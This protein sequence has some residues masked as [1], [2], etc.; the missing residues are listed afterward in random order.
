M[1]HVLLIDDDPAVSDTKHDPIKASAVTTAAI[2]LLLPTY[3]EK[4]GLRGKIRCNQQ[5]QTGQL[6]MACDLI[7][8]GRLSG[9]SHGQPPPRIVGSRSICRPVAG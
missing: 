2:E 5:T 6:S 9:G 7:I 1:A 3:D 8:R 4:L